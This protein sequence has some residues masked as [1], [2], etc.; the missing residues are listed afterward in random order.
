M[1]TVHAVGQRGRMGG[2]ERDEDLV[3]VDMRGVHR[4]R[5][6]LIRRVKKGE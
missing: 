6:R 1:R 4:R 2:D 3:A 5:A